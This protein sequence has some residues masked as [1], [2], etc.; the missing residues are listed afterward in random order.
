M[1]VGIN[2]TCTRART[3]RFIFVGT[4]F[5]LYSILAVLALFALYIMSVP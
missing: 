3:V 2:E 1:D 5:A 4:T